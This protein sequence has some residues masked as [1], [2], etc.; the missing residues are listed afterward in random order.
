MNEETLRK[1]ARFMAVIL[2]LTA[3]GLYFGFMWLTANGA[4]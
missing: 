2:G 4:L 3:V 1:R